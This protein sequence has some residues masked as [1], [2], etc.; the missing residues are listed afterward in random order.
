VSSEWTCVFRIWLK[1]SSVEMGVG[2]EEGAWEAHCPRHM[3][4]CGRNGKHG[5]VI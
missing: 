5:G 1:A 4:Q 3:A 2:G